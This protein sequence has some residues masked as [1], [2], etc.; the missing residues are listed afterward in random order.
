MPALRTVLSEKIARVRGQDRLRA[1]LTSARETGEVRLQFDG[2]PYV[3]FSCNDYLGLLHHPQVKEAAIHAVEQ[4]G[5][6]A[7]ASRLLTGNHPLY[8]ELEA[9]LAEL[10]GADAACVFGSGYLAN[11]G[12][13]P[14]LVGRG[15]VV[16]ADKLV[17]ACMLDAIQLSGAKLVRFKHNDVADL[18]AKLSQHRADYT[19]ALIATETV[20]SMDGDRAP[21]QALQKLADE[22]DAW[23]MTDDAHGL[24]ISHPADVQMGTLSKAF[25]GYGG[26]V[27][28]SKELI[29]WLQTAARSMVFSTGLPPAAVASAIAA[30]NVLQ[31]EPERAD[32][33][34]ANARQ[35]TRALGL[36][37]AESQ[38]VPLLLGDEKTALQ[39]AEDLK[40]AGFLVMAI[41][42]PTVPVGSARLRFAF[43]ANHTTEQVAALVD[44]IRRQ[45][46][47][48]EQAA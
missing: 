25:A 28:G 33:P 24:G 41:R 9:K 23:L 7:G 14:A 27:A 37:E 4:Y 19:H 17:H 46:W 22:Q 45:P 43:T 29:Q 5:A 48:Q 3:S 35:F 40:Q 38:I 36:P 31:A 16:F 34:L 12:A 42:P 15:D 11:L 26:Y 6:G 2:K 10:K 21:L 1:P 32:K 18:T 39:A 47:F 44:A 8:G 20:F 30:L 13:I